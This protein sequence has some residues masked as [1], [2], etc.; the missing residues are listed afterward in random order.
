MRRR[1]PAS[2]EFGQDAY[3]TMQPTPAADGRV[4]ATWRSGDG[5]DT[6]CPAVVM[7]P[8]GL[9]YSYMLKPQDTARTSR[10]MLAAIAELAGRDFYALAAQHAADSLYDFRRFNDRAGFQAACGGA[11][12]ASEALKLERQARDGLTAGDALGALDAFGR[13]RAAAESAFIA[14]LPS[15]GGRE[16]RGAWLHSPYVDGDDWDAFFAG[17][18]RAHLNAFFPNVCNGAH[19]DYQSDVLP[20]SKAAQQRGDQVATMIAAAHRHAV[21]VHLWRVDFN[22]F[23]P[24]RDAVDRLAAEGRLCLDQGGHIVGGPN[25]GTLCPSN[26]QNQQLEIDAMVE[27]ARRFHPDGIHFDYIRYPQIDSCYCDGCRAR[28]EVVLGRRL[29]H[30]PQDVL[31]DGP[32]RHAWLDFRRSQ[33]DRVVSEVSRRVRAEA[34]GVRITAAVF[35]DWD[36]WARD[37]IGQDWPM[38]AQK[39]WIDFACPMDYTQDVDELARDV[40]K[41]RQWVGPDFPLEIGLGAYTSPTAWHL[42]DLVDTARAN[43]ASGLMFFQVHRPRR[44]RADTCA[45]RRAVARGRAHAVGAVIRSSAS[46]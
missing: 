23:S 37:G 26:P 8:T 33:I 7:S 27:M 19:A 20:L 24:G 3:N 34:P 45:A 38:W 28:F 9:Y 42:A 41:Q 46:T 18:R 40:A 16:F 4:L 2:P 30:W 10:F 31:S 29:A 44:E 14:A 22:L 6:G 5:A 1:R 17:M 39:G 32:V 11:P 12:A 35:T 36:T 21:E 25:S 13:A 43:G 15:R